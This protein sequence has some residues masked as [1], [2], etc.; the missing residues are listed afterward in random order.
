MRKGVRLTLFILLFSLSA[1]SQVNRYGTPLISS[2]DALRHT[3]GLRC[4]SITADSRGVIFFACESG[5]VASFNGS[6]W[7]RAA[8]PW[9]VATLVTDGHG[10][11]WAGGRGGFGVLQPDGGGRLAW[12]PV[13]AMISDSVITEATGPIIAGTADSSN[14]YLTDGSRIYMPRIDGGPAG[15]ADLG[16]RSGLSRITAMLIFDNRLIIADENEGLFSFR[17]GEATALRGGRSVAGTPVKK[18]LPFDRETLL[19]IYSD[20]SPALFNVKNGTIAGSFGGPEGEALFSSRLTGDVVLLPGNL[21]AAG[22]RERGGLAI[23][24]HEGKLLQLISDATTTLGESSVTAMYC[25]YKSNGQLWFSSRGLISKANVSL[26][27]TEFNS[28][29]GLPPV[30]GPLASL[31]GTLFVASDDGL[32]VSYTD[33]HHIRRFRRA[34]SQGRVVNDLAAVSLPAG[35]M[36]LA[37]ATNGLMQIDPDGEITRFLP[38]MAFTALCPMRG[39][40]AVVLT[41]AA[42]GTLYTLGYDGGA[43]SVAGT[44]HG[45][46]NG[47]VREILQTSPSEWWLVTSLP[48]ALIRMQ[49]R[50]S[51]TLFTRYGRTKGLTCDTINSAA[52]VNDRLYIAT[53]KGIFTYDSDADTIYRSHGLTGDLFDNANIRLI[54]QTPE[55]E[56][57]VSGSD[58]RNFDAI[59]TLTSQGHVVFRRQFDFLPDAPTRDILCS[60]GTIWISKGCKLYALDRSKLAYRYG[61]FSTFFIRITGRND[62][63]LM[64]GT[65]FSTTSS[66]IRVATARQ[67]DRERV[68]LRHTENDIGFE[69]TTTAFV[70]VS[71]TEYRYRLDGYEQGWSSWTRRNYRDY[72]NLPSGRYLF[73]VKARTVTGL[74]GEELTYAFSVRKPWYASTL[75]TLLYILL[76]VWLIIMLTGYLSRRLDQ[77]RR[78]LEGLLRQRN[79]ATARGRSEIAGLERYAAVVQSVI[80]PSERRLRETIPNSFLLNLPKKEVSGDFFWMRHQGDR[81]L[82]AVGDCT[83]HGIRSSLRTAMALSLLEEIAGHP[84]SNT[85]SSML[86]EFRRR[87][88]GSISAL[89]P[90]DSQYEGIDI[91]LLGID[92]T[93]KRIEYSGAAMQCFRVRVM[94]EQEIMRWDRGEFKPNEGTQVSGR[95]LLETV[96]GDRIPLGMHLDSDQVFTQHNWK[97][98]KEATYYLFTDGYSDQF[99][100][101]TGRKFM[102]KNLRKLILDIQDYHLNMQKDILEERLRSWM[103]KAPQTDDILVVGIRIE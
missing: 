40:N 44:L 23:F 89:P 39:N 11:V 9:P 82:V 4:H 13:S 77:R 74:E 66:G 67:P 38:E 31:A 78:R 22:F 7:D 18:L 34:G 33:D 69:W 32:S 5:G 16:S 98:E 28:G 90:H 51:D 21:I 88:A 35:R 27:V 96:Y 36:M 64:E 103:G 49:Y 62:R 61:S 71:A 47:A 10:V 97:L 45:K 48:S 50:S 26:P 91:S 25:D 83:G 63:V 3:G 29:S 30:T 12:H 65:F 17:E 100:G 19:V 73:R 1:A 92:R 52:V 60:D 54:A 15:V 86:Y 102:K 75:A 8:T 72:T 93:R 99:N 87:L 101:V 6:R 76:A 56:L 2:F 24:S 94:S 58:T 46:I 42:D 14:T 43:W 53:G 95:H 79:E 84:E 80:N 85:T 57:V 20:R 37:A 41:G 70:D 81:T 55:G 68:V 59:V